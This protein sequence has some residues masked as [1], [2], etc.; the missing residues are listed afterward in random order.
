MY[1]LY[2]GGAMT[3]KEQVYRELR[4]HLMSRAMRPGDRILEVPLAEK[5]G[6]S[7]IPLREAIDQ[8]AGE[9]LVE[10]VPGLG[11]YVRSASPKDLREIYEIREVLECYAVEK[12]AG[13]MSGAQL[14]HLDDLCGEIRSALAEYRRTGKW[15]PAIRE[16]LVA[17][18]S[19]FHQ[20]IA[21]AADNEHLRKEIARLQTV[22]ELLSYRL[23]V[24]ADELE[25]M[26]R[27]A[28]EHLG[29]LESLRRSNGAGARGRMSKHIRRAGE[30]AL[31]VVEEL[32][33]RDAGARSRMGEPS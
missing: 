25:A 19:R 32:S 24:A 9:G 22:S 26:T 10:R 13:R 6:V 21:A 31:A 5:L 15:T 7:R 27:S 14:G 12:V 20:T 8:L 18:D 29:I 28:E 11:S 3:K 17:A 23:E 2:T 16:R 30:R 33:R 1:V 4:G